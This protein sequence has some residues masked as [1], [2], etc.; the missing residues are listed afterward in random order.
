MGSNMPFIILRH[1]EMDGEKKVEPQ[2][3][4]YSA[5]GLDTLLDEA[6]KQHPDAT[7]THHMT[8]IVHK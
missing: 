4:A 3:I 6:K 1:E 7:F 8:H 5:K 2:G